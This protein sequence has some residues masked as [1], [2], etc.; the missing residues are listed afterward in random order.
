MIAMRY[1]PQI[2]GDWKKKLRENWFYAF[3]TGLKRKVFTEEIKN[4]DEPN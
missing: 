4:F 1:F 2:S 3:P